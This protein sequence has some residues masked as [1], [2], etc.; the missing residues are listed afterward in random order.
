MN[1]ASPID[2]KRAEKISLPVVFRE[3]RKREN[4]WTQKTTEKRSARRPIVVPAV[5]DPVL[6][7][8]IKDYDE[9][10]RLFRTMTDVLQI[11]RATIDDI[12]GLPEGLASKI[13]SLKKIRRLGMETLGDMLDVLCIKLV[14]VF[15]EQ[16][17]E[18]NRHRFIRRDNPHYTS[19][20]KG[21][22]KPKPV[23][24]KTV[25]KITGTITGRM[26]HW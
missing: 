26:G 20:R 18:R 22:E 25:K 4:S 8:E 16:A 13:L 19:A 11:S 17:F 2:I 24:F 21:H 3:C 9:L 10:L 6:P 5:P 15:D 12:A 7:S 14:P 23:T 1:D